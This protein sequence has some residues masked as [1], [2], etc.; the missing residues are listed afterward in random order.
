MKNEPK[1]SSL[2]DKA[3]FDY[4]LIEENLYK[5]NLIKKFYNEK[6]AN[7]LLDDLRK[8]YGSRD[9]NNSNVVLRNTLVN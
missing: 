8:K 4:Q 9:Y 1:I 2:I 7:Y 5:A 3:I 6:R